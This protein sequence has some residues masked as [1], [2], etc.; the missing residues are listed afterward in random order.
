MTLDGSGAEDL[1]IIHTQNRKLA[2]SHIFM[3]TLQ[4]NLI[5]LSYGRIWYVLKDIGLFTYTM[6]NSRAV[7]KI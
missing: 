4:H 1:Y 6:T 2:A 5:L 7:N 3:N